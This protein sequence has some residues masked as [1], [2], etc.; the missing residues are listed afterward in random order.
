VCL[1]LSICWFF[2]VAYYLPFVSWCFLGLGSKLFLFPKPM[3]FLM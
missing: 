2:V 3:L 1:L